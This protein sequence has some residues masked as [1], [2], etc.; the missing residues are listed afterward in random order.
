MGQ[1]QTTLVSQAGLYDFAINGGAIGTINMGVYIPK[2]AIVTSFKVAVLTTFVGAGAVIAFG[3]TPGT[4]QLLMVNSGVEQFTANAAING[5]DLSANP[6]LAT[7]FLQVT[8]TISTA[9]LTAGKLKFLIN[10]NTFQL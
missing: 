1:L 5:V 7:D 3:L 8:M 10:H 4:S 2:F 6:F 9:A